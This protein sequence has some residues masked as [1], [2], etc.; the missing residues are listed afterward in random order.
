MKRTFK[1]FVTLLVLIAVP[2]LAGLGIM[3]L[4]NGIIPSTCGFHEITFYQAIG[5]FLLG[6]LLS[7]GFIMA[8][9]FGFWSLHAI[10]HSHGDW[11]NH[12]HNMSDKERLEFIK[13]RREHFGFHKHIHTVENAS[14]E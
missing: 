1:I 8:L 11:R 10:V 14:E 2:V 12:W 13:R 6:Q 4:W 9:F 5:L 3:A 7:T